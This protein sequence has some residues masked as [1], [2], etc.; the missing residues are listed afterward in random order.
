MRGERR[1]D[2]RGRRLRFPRTIIGGAGV[3]G[4]AKQPQVHF[5]VWRQAYVLGPS[6]L[7]F[8][9]GKQKLLDP[10]DWYD[11][12]MTNTSIPRPKPYR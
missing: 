10:Y 4:N 1:I 6:Q 11:R 5:E 12:P 9:R 3:S 7:D 2:S 8:T